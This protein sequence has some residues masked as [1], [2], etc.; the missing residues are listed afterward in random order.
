R[1]RPTARALRGR[2]LGADPRREHG[3]VRGR[4]AR[5]DPGDGAAALA[6]TDR[7][8]AAGGHDLDL[9]L[10]GRGGRLPGAAAR[11]LRRGA[12]IMTTSVRIRVGLREYQLELD[13]R[14]N[15]GGGILLGPREAL[16]T[17][18]QVRDP[19]AWATIERVVASLGARHFDGD[20]DLGLRGSSI[21]SLLMTGR[22][23]IRAIEARGLRVLSSEPRPELEPEREE[24]LIDETHSVMI[25]LLDAEGN[26]VPGEPFRIELPDGSIRSLTL[27]DQGKAH[28]TGIEQPGT[29]KVCFYERDA[30]VW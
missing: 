12:V 5:R 26:P 2:R 22:L 15:V 1:A 27:D 29:F 30:S 10:G 4:D 28:V 23:R 19:A 3:H 7:G 24:N 16:R 6:A 8:R 21:T 14:S 20:E 13:T 11:D 18:A 25:E 9:R 17:L